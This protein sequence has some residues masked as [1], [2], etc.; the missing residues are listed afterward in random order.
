[1]KVL[2]KKILIALSCLLLALTSILLASCGEEGNA[3]N[4]AKVATSSEVADYV[5]VAATNYLKDRTDLTKFADTTYTASSEFARNF[6]NT[7]EYKKN[8]EDE[9]TIT[10]D[11]TNV[12]TEKANV[13]LSIKKVNNDFVIVINAE[14]TTYEKAYSVST[15]AETLDTLVVS[16]QTQIDS[17]TYTYAPITVEE[18]TTYYLIEEATS[19]IKVP[20]KDDVK[21]SLKGKY[22]FANKAAYDAQVN[23]ILTAMNDNTINYFFGMYSESDPMSA[24]MSVLLLNG[25]KDGDNLTL[26]YGLNVPTIGKSSHDY[27]ITKT[28]NNAKI[29]FKNNN[30]DT[31]NMTSSYKSK[32]ISIDTNA[33]VKIANGSNPTIISELSDDYLNNSGI[34]AEVDSI[35][36]E[37]KELGASD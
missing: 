34:Q 16:E 36:E 24:M 28:A 23:V 5:E 13:V 25:V 12:N 2:T 21:N 37:I 18:E 19:T 17:A 8:K 20:N 15:D 1:M 9:E 3:T 6:T 4:G 11:F 31:M 32:T 26:E 33:C 7:L 14:R 27:A 22:A 35:M 29:E 30:V 10:E